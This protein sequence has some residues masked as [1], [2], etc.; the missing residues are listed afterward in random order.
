MDVINIVYI[1]SGYVMV[2]YHWTSEAEATMASN[3][4]SSHLHKTSATT[5]T[6]LRWRQRELVLRSTW[7]PRGRRC[8][9]LAS[10]VSDAMITNN[11]SEDIISN[12]QILPPFNQR[13]S[14]LNRLTN[15]IDSWYT[16]AN[17]KKKYAKLFLW[18]NTTTDWQHI[19][20]KIKICMNCV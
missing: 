6:M 5:V 19:Y 3:P 4:T 20:T 11:S 18:S 12:G 17:R 1:F 2:L 15:W 9:G 8:Y 7:R 13:L 14:V 10:S 16:S